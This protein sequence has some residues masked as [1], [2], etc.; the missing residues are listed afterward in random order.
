[1][2]LPHGGKSPKHKKLP[3]LLNRHQQANLAVRVIGAFLLLA[4]V[5]VAAFI[6]HGRLMGGGAGGGSGAVLEKRIGASTGP[7]APSAAAGAAAG[8]GAATKA[9]KAKVRV[10]GHACAVLRLNRFTWDGG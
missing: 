9:A 8:A 2:L 1:M 4:V 10:C 5:L 3:R 7:K 6:P